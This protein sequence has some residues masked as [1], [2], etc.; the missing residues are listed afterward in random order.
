MAPVVSK[1]PAYLADKKAVRL[2]V[3]ANFGAEADELAQRFPVPHGVCIQMM[4]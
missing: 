3:F 1:N 4:C 2:T